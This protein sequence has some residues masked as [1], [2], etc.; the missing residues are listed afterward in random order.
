MMTVQ[1]DITLKAQGACQNTR[2][3]ARIFRPL[4]WS[5]ARRAPAILMNAAGAKLCGCSRAGSSASMRDQ[6]GCRTGRYSSAHRLK[7]GIVYQWLDHTLFMRS[8]RVL[9]AIISITVS[10]GVAPHRC[11]LR[12]LGHVA[13][14][15][16]RP[17]YDRMQ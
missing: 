15:L 3:G 5:G 13:E 10:Y 2:V 17:L 12:G 9:I 1:A 8:M 4:T 16:R 7:V 6:P 14:A 11:S